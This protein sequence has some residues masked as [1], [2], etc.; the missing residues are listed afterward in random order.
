M[1]KIQFNSYLACA[2]AEGFC[3]G[4]NATKEEQL[5]AWAY[6][7]KTGEC[8]KLQGFYGRTADQLIKLKYISKDGEVLKHA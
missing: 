4:E 3:E 1:S 5:E 8:Y 7:I 2:Y 6:L